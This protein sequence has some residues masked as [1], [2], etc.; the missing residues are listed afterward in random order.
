MIQGI[1]IVFIAVIIFI[2]IDNGV[3]ALAR[4]LA[5]AFIAS[6]NVRKAC[7]RSP[8]VIV[9]AGTLAERYLGTVLSKDLDVQPARLELL[10]ENL[11]AFGN[12]GSG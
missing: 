9:E 3:P 10:E 4:A 12:T 2:E 8:L 5:L 11:T 6:L 1:V 7:G